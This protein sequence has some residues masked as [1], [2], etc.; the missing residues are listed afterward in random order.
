MM[1]EYEPR[2][3]NRLVLDTTRPV[4]VSYQELAAHLSLE[5]LH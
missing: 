2:T 1:D 4:E 3:G 5:E